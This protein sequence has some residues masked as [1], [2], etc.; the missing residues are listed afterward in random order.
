M[1]S[2]TSWHLD[3]REQ[4]IKKLVSYTPSLTKLCDF[5]FGLGLTRFPKLQKCKPCNAALASEHYASEMGVLMQ[6]IQTRCS[7]H[8]G[9]TARIMK[10]CTIWCCVDSFCTPSPSPVKNNCFLAIL[11]TELLPPGRSIKKREC[12]GV[13]LGIALPLGPPSQNNFVP[14]V[15]WFFDSH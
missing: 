5:P 7:F 10:F 8:W 1:R 9:Y 6:H 14:S 12:H 15:T 3:N 13:D 11:S 2:T 4:E